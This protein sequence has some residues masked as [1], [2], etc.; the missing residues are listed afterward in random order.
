MRASGRKE[1]VAA[2]VVGLMAA[3]LGSTS[4]AEEKNLAAARYG[5]QVIKYTSQLGDSRRAEMLIDGHGTSGGW[6]SSDASL[7]QEIII[8]LP[9]V[10]RFNTLVFN[11]ASEG[12]D[13]GW[14]KEISVYTAEPFPTMGGWKLVAHLELA[15]QPADQVFTVAPADGRFVRLL[16]TSTQSL[17]ATRVSLNEFRLFM[18]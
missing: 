6:A 4:F 1:R 8:R 2:I 15:R 18:R 7:P 16:I 17:D 13:A 10:A 11:L 14:A 3:S 12:P 5:A 9:A